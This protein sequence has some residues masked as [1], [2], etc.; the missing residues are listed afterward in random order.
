MQLLGRCYLCFWC[1]HQ[2]L[3]QHFREQQRAPCK[4]MSGGLKKFPDF[5]LCPGASHGTIRERRC[6][7]DSAPIATK[8][9][10]KV[11]GECQLSFALPFSSIREFSAKGTISNFRSN[12]RRDTCNYVLTNCTIVSSLSILQ[13]VCICKSAPRLSFAL[14]FGSIR[15]FSA[16]RFI[17]NFRSNSWCGEHATIF[18]APPFLQYCSDRVQL[19][20][21]R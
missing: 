21:D 16:K 2:D 11:R 7:V 4:S 9:G 17:S 18:N 1:R 10:A 19:Y 8:L 20:R 3:Y 13:S 14:L 6:S 5:S 12:S 15:A